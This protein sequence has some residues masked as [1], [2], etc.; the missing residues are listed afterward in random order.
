MVCILNV[1][2][3]VQFHFQALRKVVNISLKCH[4][5]NLKR[6][7]ASIIIM[8]LL[9][10]PFEEMYHAYPCSW[11][12][13]LLCYF[14]VL[15]HCYCFATVNLNPPPPFVRILIMSPFWYLT[16]VFSQVIV[17]LCVVSL[18]NDPL[19]KL[20]KTAWSR[21]LLSWSLCEM[22]HW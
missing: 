20:I 14:S 18:W 7:R 13:V 6:L 11:F 1:H 3:I 8:H 17:T 5:F 22:T 21:A 2:G 10:W 16:L 4:V 9:A 15:L 12:G 19:I